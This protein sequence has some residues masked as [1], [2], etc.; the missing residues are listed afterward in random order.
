MYP[1][2]KSLRHLILLFTLKTSTRIYI[3]KV[4]L[5][6]VKSNVGVFPISEEFSISDDENKRR[7]KDL[8]RT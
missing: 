1:K 8:I 4:H 3:K 5:S 7:W 2:L 6:S